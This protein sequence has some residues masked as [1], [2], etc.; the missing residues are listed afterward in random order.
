MAFPIR[1]LALPDSQLLRRPLRGPI[2]D[3]Y[4]AETRSHLRWA[5]GII[6]VRKTL[7][8]QELKLA[9]LLDPMDKSVL[10]ELQAT[11]AAKDSEAFRA[12]YEQTLSSCYACHVAAGK[13]FLRLQIPQQPEA[14]I[15]RFAPEP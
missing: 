12:K 11:I 3:F 2:R 7:Q 5:V 10:K 8:G 13:P 14:Q 1:Y 4:L 15:I 9:D 6:P